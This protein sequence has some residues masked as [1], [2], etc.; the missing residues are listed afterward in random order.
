MKTAITAIA[1]VLGIGLVA[2]SAHAQTMGPMGPFGVTS[3]VTPIAA[4]WQA[5]KIPAHLTT[6][7]MAR[8]Y[9]TPLGGIGITGPLRNV[10]LSPLLQQATATSPQGFSVANR[11]GTAYANPRGTGYASPFAGTVNVPSPLSAMLPPP[12]PGP[13]SVAE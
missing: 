13:F 3:P 6:L 10:H 7:A 12:L 8:P 2:T 5:A 1:L 11:G 9:V 4:A